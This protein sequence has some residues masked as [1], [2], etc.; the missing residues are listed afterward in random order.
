MC[1]CHFEYSD[2]DQQV[3]RGTQRDTGGHRGIQGT[4]ETVQRW[5]KL[6]AEKVE[7]ED[8]EEWKREEG[9]CSREVGGL[10]LGLVVGVS[11]KK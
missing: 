4:E 8:S 11:R 10:R 2:W 9:E 5:D 7:V 1:H 6:L 3:H